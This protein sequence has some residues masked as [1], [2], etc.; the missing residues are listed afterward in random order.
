MDA[1]SVQK[2]NKDLVYASK[3]DGKMHAC[4]HDAHTSMLLVAAKALNEVK[5][6]LPG[7]VRLVFQPAEEIAEGAKSLVKQGAM[8]G[9]DNVFGI[10]IW[11]QIPTGKISCSPGPS[12]A[13]ADRFIVT[14][15]GRGGH[16]AMPHECIDAAVVAS[17]FVMNIQSVVSRTID[18]QESAV[19]TVGKMTVGTRFNVIAENAA[20]EGTIRCFDSGVR[21]Y[22]ETQIAQFADQTAA[23]YG[24]NAEV[25]YIHG[26]Q[27]VLNE[28]SSAKLVQS[29]VREAYGGDMI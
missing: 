18:P 29:I 6:D 27:A 21:S 23:L 28:A 13:A 11:S 8:E 17:T 16:G 10:H 12:F 4:G 14:F 3:K 25:N 19:L 22:M 24:A 7:L 1:L 5:D 2:L 20:I 9:V 26:T 15:K